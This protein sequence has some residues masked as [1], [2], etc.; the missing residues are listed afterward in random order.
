MPLS[1]VRIIESELIPHRLPASDVDSFYFLDDHFKD[2]LMDL[3]RCCHLIEAHHAC[4]RSRLPS[5]LASFGHCRDVVQHRLLGLP[6]SCGHGEIARL[7]GLVFTYGVTYPLPRPNILCSSSALLL[8]ALA[9]TVYLP[10]QSDEFLLWAAM[11]GA[12]GMGGA[13]GETNG[14][15]PCLRNIK[16]RL[17]ITEW[18]DSKMICSKF[19]WLGQACD[20][21]AALVWDML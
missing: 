7:A 19:V 15:I 4:K 21:G 2:I 18:E 10:G 6:H 13:E 8:Q 9:E 3:R 12:L 20:E 1:A 14:F 17:N 5:S 11:V 16:D